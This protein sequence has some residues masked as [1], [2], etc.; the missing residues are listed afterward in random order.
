[1]TW[2]HEIDAEYG[3]V[4]QSNL[5]VSGMDKND[6]SLSGSPLVRRALAC[7]T[8]TVSSLEEAVELATRFK[9]EGKYDWFR[10]QQQ[11]WPLYPTAARKGTD[12]EE[13]TDIT[14][15][16]CF[17]LCW[18]RQTA[19]ISEIANDIDAVLAIAQHHG[20][21]TSLLDFTTDP[22]VAGYFASSGKKSSKG[23]GF[24]YCLRTND[25]RRFHQEMRDYSSDY[26]ELAEIV[27]IQPN[28]PNLWRVEAQHGV[29]LFAPSNFFDYYLIDKIE[30]PHPSGL[31]FPTT[32]DIYPERKSQLEL[33][34]DHFFKLLAN[35]RFQGA[36]RKEFP[37]AIVHHLEPPKDRVEPEF[38]KR[39]AL[40]RMP[41]WSKSRMESWKLLPTERLRE[42]SLVEIGLEVDLRSEAG[43]L[44]S[45]IAFG[46]T[47][48]LSLD[49]LLRK[50]A[51]NWVLLPQR[52]LQAKLREAIDLVW[53]GMRMLP[54]DDEVI[55]DAIAL[56][57]AL[58]RSGFRDATEEEAHAIATGLLGT[59]IRIG[60]GDSNGSSSRGYAAAA[61]LQRATRGDL[62]TRMLR[63]YLR[64]VSSPSAVL[65][66]CLAPERLFEF[67]PFIRLF[68]SQIV[69]TQ[70]MRA[71]AGGVFFSPARIEGFGL[72]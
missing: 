18:I 52:R 23:K 4:S 48:A 7:E 36:I 55:A 2:F 30:F 31:C 24:I 5:K 17:L 61:D 68:G 43:E 59:C 46:V 63:K 27:F 50:K 29:F 60:I 44:R 9:N 54:Y 39:G 1:M 3:R 64:Y 70:V 26:R 67:D 45:R 11:D 20:L 14:D 42:T 21:P 8:Y 6:L 65:Q 51:V 35:S 47:R 38:F 25:L 12:P 34:L 15:D 66:M 41:C 53:N 40:P 49:P 71:H 62:P 58:H 56:C 10:G 22:G 72:P 32:R 57:F 16:L 28:V 33:Q 13:Q 69:P 19:G 37:D